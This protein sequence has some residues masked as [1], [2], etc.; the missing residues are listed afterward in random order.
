MFK[1]KTWNLK[2]KEIPKCQCHHPALL[3]IM[4]PQQ[5]DLKYGLNV[6]GNVRQCKLQLMY[7]YEYISK[8]AIIYNKIHLLLKIKN[9][10]VYNSLPYSIYILS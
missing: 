9:Q 8:Q 3:I 4:Q 10:D 7:T 5:S 1:S 2:E 6:E